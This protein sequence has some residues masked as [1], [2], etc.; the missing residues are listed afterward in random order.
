MDTLKTKTAK[1][2][3]VVF[4]FVSLIHPPGVASTARYR[5]HIDKMYILWWNDRIH[6]MNNTSELPAAAV[7][8][9]CVSNRINYDLNPDFLQAI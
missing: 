5:V 8:E 2:N 1:S 7:L 9:L 6:L 4:N 3:H